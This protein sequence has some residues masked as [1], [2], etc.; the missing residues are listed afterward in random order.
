MQ[1][2]DG[3]SAEVAPAVSAAVQ[4]LHDDLVTEIHKRELS[5]SENFDKSILTLSS[6]GLAVSIGFLK[7][8]VPI[9]GASQPWALYVSW[10]AFVSATAATMVSFLVSGYSQVNQKERAYRYYILGEQ[11]AFNKPNQ[12]D[13]WI[14]RLNIFS[15]AAFLIALVLTIIF[16]S[17]NLEKGSA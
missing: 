9:Q 5:A 2:S 15:A 6:G 11:A 16:I 3:V 7:D 17:I 1:K 13:T 14:P 8:F 10:I 4:K 12:Y